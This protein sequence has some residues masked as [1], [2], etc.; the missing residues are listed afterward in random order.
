MKSQ[1]HAACRVGT[2]DRQYLGGDFRRVRLEFKFIAVRRH[3]RAPVRDRDAVDVRIDE[4]VR[5]VDQQ[6][7]KPG[8]GESLPYG[9]CS[10]LTFV[11]AVGVGSR[12]EVPPGRRTWAGGPAAD[13]CGRPARRRRPPSRVDSRRAAKHRLRTGGSGSG[14]LLTSTISRNN[15]GLPAS[16]PTMTS[17]RF[18]SIFFPLRGPGLPTVA[19]RAW[20]LQFDASSAR[21][22]RHTQS[23]G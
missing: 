16:T 9:R 18:A 8:V 15:S 13:P 21:S 3:V 23:Q 10:L 2:D 7:T 11:P 5:R 22:S 20:P 14:G 17:L 1:H 19:S 4:R 6:A 12:I